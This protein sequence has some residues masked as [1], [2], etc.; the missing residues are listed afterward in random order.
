MFSDPLAKCCAGKQP[1]AHFFE[2]FFGHANRAH[3]VVDTT[4]SKAALRNLEPASFAQQDVFSRDAN[5][6]QLDLHMAMRRIIIA[7]DR[8]MTQHLYPL[9]IKRHQY[10][11]LLRVAF[12]LG[13]GFAHDN[14]NFTARVTHA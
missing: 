8:Q 11:R 9:R 6:F 5:V 4:R 10:L 12:C 14:R 7:K 2:R 13:I 3:A 1:L